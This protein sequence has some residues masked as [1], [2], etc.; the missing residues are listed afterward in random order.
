MSV[1]PPAVADLFYP[2]DVQ[3]LRAMIDGFISKAQSTL[4]LRPSTKPKALI[5]PHAGYIY[6]GQCAAYAYATLLAA[7]PQRV[8]LLAPAHRLPFY[9]MALSSADAFATP[10][11]TIALD[12]QLNE[13]LLT[14]PDVA[15]NDAAH[16]QEHA[17]EVHLPFLQ[18]LLGDVSLLPVCIGTV[19]PLAVSALLAQLWSLP[20]T[21][22]LISS[23]LSH[24]HPYATANAIDQ[25]SIA[26]ILQFQPL[27]HTEACGA[28][29]I[30][31]LLTL[32]A[33]HHLTPQLLDYRNSG[34]TAG[35]KERVVGYAAIAFDTAERA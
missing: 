15:I 35:D 3:A 12:Q 14:L 24:Y 18:H 9:G 10:F 13:Q 26:K 23:D 32:A 7:K 11:G 34:D 33:Q 29:G 19:D 20:E 27:S 25:Q 1:R 31:G 5:A 2:A 30:N 4:P 21:L 16:A 8:V 17:I 6:S 22:F 28:T